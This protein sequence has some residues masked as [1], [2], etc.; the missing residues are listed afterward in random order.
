MTNDWGLDLFRPAKW[1]TQSLALP[2]SSGTQPLV[3]KASLHKRGLSSLPIAAQQPPEEELPTSS[4]GSSINSTLRAPSSSGSSS[5]SS[6]GGVKHSRSP[7]F[8]RAPSVPM[9]FSPAVYHLAVLFDLALRFAWS[10]KLSSHL[11]LLT[12]IEAGIF[13]LEALE[14][15]RRM[16]WCV[17]RIEWEH[18]KTRAWER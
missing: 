3:G 5:G 7:S 16:A 13:A 15:A 2:S 9:L 8:L 17:L 11:S 6:H 4:S 1:F 14:I 10:L 18:V 12:E